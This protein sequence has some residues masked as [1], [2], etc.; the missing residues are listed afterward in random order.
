M[1]YDQS[2]AIWANKIWDGFWQISFYI[3]KNQFRMYF[4]PP[5]NL[6]SEKDK[7]WF[8]PWFNILLQPQEAWQI[9]IWGFFSKILETSEVYL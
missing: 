9:R 3:K 6:R 5:K 2:A 1:I 7:S 4:Y 8:K